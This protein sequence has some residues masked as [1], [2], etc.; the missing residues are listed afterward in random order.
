ML[1]VTRVRTATKITAGVHHPHRRVGCLGRACITVTFV[2]FLNIQG[3]AA[4][5]QQIGQLRG[6]VVAV[7]PDQKK[8][9]PGIKVILTSATTQ[10]RFEVVS[11][12]EGNYLFGGLSAGDYSL[13][14]DVSGFEK[15]EQS[16]SLQIDAVVDLNILLTPAGPSAGVTV[17][18]DP[19]LAARTQSSVSGQL[20]TQNLSDAPLI[21]EKFQ[22]ALPLLPG[23]VRGPDGLMNLKGS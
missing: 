1:Q 5:P 11:D 4:V 7:T 13:T 6:T 21:N 18:A 9:L 15:F 19:D 22:D 14:V 8:R 16:V 10:R 17:T 2:L 12:D 3:M 20:T 23:V